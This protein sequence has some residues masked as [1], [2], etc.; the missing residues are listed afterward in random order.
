MFHG[1]LRNVTIDR[2]FTGV[3][4]T[5]C[6]AGVRPVRGML[7]KFM[8][9]DVLETDYVGIRLARAGRFAPTSSSRASWLLA[10][11]RFARL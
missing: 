5:R 4:S 9:K 8:I 11:H 3:N 2:C 6:G 7:L 1:V 10:P